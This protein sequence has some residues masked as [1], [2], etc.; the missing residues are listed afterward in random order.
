MGKQRCKSWYPEI[1]KYQTYHIS[2]KYVSKGM[3]HND[4]IIVKF[5]K[6]G[7]NFNKEEYSKNKRCKGCPLQSLKM[8]E[9]IDFS[10]LLKIYLSKDS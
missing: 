5:W 4:A 3:E 7:K 9:E 8:K 6:N 10:V 1:N 2:W